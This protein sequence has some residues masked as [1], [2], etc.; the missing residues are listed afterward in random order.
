MNKIHVFQ[1]VSAAIFI[2]AVTI[3]SF[4]SILGV[5]NVFAVDVIQK[6]FLTLGLLS[7]VAIVI[8]IA[9]RY[10]DRQPEDPNIIPAGAG[11]F[12]AIRRITVVMLI[13]SAGLL[14][15]LGILSIWEVITNQDVV[16]RSLSS[17]AIIAFA[18]LISVMVCLERENSP[19]ARSSGNRRFG[20][21][22]VLIVVIV[23]TSLSFMRY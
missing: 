19:L 11:A 20:W 14:A 3:L 5:W 9:G 13:I 8:I 1:D 22:I 17:L 18:S 2:G 16:Y 15:L 23:W 21:L 7:I 6:S 4:V 10:I 12:R